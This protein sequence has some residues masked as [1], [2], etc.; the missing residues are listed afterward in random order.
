MYGFPDTTT[1]PYLEPRIRLS[2]DVR[3]N[4]PPKPLTPPLWQS[5]LL[6]L[7]SKIG[8]IAAENSPEGGAGF[9]GSTISS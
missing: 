5:E 1:V 8:L 7:R 2:Y 3:S 6:Q 9:R 4:P